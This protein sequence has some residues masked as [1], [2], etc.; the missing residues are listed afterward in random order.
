[1]MTSLP[2]CF[3]SRSPTHSSWSV[4]SLLLCICLLH[5]MSYT[6]DVYS[7]FKRQKW[8]EWYLEIIFYFIFTVKSSI[9]FLLLGSSCLR[10]GF[11]SETVF[12]WP[13][14]FIAG[15]SLSPVLFCLVSLVSAQAQVIC[16]SV[17]TQRAPRALPACLP[18]C[19]AAWVQ[20]WCAP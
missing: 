5:N 8:S 16:G 20:A 6:L 17:F 14:L 3:P 11:L 1:M 15:W 12:L 4:G 10:V 2:R 19:P 9:C 13:N 18:H 7:A